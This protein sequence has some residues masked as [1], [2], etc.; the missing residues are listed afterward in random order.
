MAKFLLQVNSAYIARKKP[1]PYA[2][3][4]AM[5]MRDAPYATANAMNMSHAPC[6]YMQMIKHM[7]KHIIILLL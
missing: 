7:I 5:N 2:T 3:A 4:N 6:P 1:C